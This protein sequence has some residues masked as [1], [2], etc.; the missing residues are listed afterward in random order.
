MPECYADTLF[1]ET[2]VPTKAGYNHK[3]GCFNVQAEMR[4]GC[5]KESFAVGILDNDKNR[6]PYLDNFLEIDK[7]N[8]SLILWKHRDKSHFIIQ[9]CPALE[10]WI[11]NLCISKNIRMEEFNLPGE[12]DAFRKYTKSKDRVE[13]ENLQDLFKKIASLEI[14]EVRKIRHWLTLLREKNY[15]VDINELRNG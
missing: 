8:G 4:S 10:K 2:L 9:I 13:D 15:D 12:L 14:L 1:V 6:L 7:V 11:L 3:M 5:L